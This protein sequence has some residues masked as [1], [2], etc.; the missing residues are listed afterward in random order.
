[1]QLWLAALVLAECNISCL[2]AEGGEELE[3]GTF[4]VS[5]AAIGEADVD[6]TTLLSMIAPFSFTHNSHPQI[7]LPEL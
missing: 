4:P 1:M 6:A 5:G 7:S 2:A 3:Q